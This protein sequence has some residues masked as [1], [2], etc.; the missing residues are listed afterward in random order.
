MLADVP[1]DVLLTPGAGSSCD[2][3]SLVA[4]DELLPGRVK[5]MDFPYRLAGRK[6]PDKQPVL[7]QSLVDGA[8]DMAAGPLILGGRSMGGRMCSIAAAQ[9]LINVRA[10]ILIC[11]PLHPPGKP[12]A[13]RTDHFPE[14]L[15]PCLFISGTKDAFGTPDEL[16]KASSLIP[17]RVE[18]VWIEGADHSLRRKD[19][20]VAAI[21]LSGST[22]FRVNGLQG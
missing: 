15:M 4:I 8:A 18:H 13:L 7:L 1:A 9:K 3:A 21:G 6:F 16:T 12:D 11:Y 2:H 20:D 19:A 22:V 10:L 14:L 17:G 5:R